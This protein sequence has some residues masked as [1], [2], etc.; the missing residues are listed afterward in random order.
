MFMWMLLLLFIL[1]CVKSANLSCQPR[2]G[3]R[4]KCP[5][6]VLWDI[7][8]CMLFEK[9]IQINIHLLRDVTAVPAL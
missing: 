1:F 7:F 6:V 8:V 5:P 9:D 2:V 4:I 3:K